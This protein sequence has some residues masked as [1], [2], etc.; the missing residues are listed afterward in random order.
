M[1]VASCGTIIK[2]SNWAGDFRDEG[3]SNIEIL[4]HVHKFSRK[5]LY[6]VNGTQV[7]FSLKSL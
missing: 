4:K 2:A 6:D 3:F 5:K 7:K 1:H